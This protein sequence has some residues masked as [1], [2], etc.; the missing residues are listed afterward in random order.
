MKTPFFGNIFNKQKNSYPDADSYQECLEYLKSDQDAVRRDA[1]KSI[2]QNHISKI[3]DTEP[4]GDVMRNDRSLD[5]QNLAMSILGRIGTQECIDQI[6][7]MATLPDSYTRAQAISVLTEMKNVN[8][9]YTLK[10]TYGKVRPEYQHAIK[11]ALDKMREEMHIDDRDAIVSGK[12]SPSMLKAALPKIQETLSENKEAKKPAKQQTMMDFE[13]EEKSPSQSKLSYEIVD[14]DDDSL[15]AGGA[16]DLDGADDDENPLQNLRDSKSQKLLQEAAAMYSASSPSNKMSSRTI[17]D[18]KYPGSEDSGRTEAEQPIF[19]ADQPAVI[20][21]PEKAEIRDDEKSPAPDMNKKTRIS[22]MLA[23]QLQNVSNSPADP[24]ILDAFISAYVSDSE[25]A[26][27]F[28]ASCASEPD[29]P[30]SIQALQAIMSLKNQDRFR[31]IY[32]SKLKSQS[33][34]TVAKGLIP[35]L[36]SDDI[37]TAEAVF[38]LTE[39]S[40]ERVKKFA[41]NYFVNNTSRELSDFLY[42]KITN[43]NDEEKIIGASLLAR[44]DIKDTRKHLKKLLQD[45]GTQDEIILSIFSRLSPAYSDVVIASLPAL[46]QRDDERI[47]L[48]TSKFLEDSDDLI[49]EEYLLRNLQTKDD[50]KL[51]GK[52]ILLLAKIKSRRGEAYLPSMI[53]DLSPYTKLQTAKAICEYGKP[54]YYNLI[55]LA[56]ESDKHPANRIEFVKMAADIYGRNITP[57]LLSMIQNEIPDVKFAIIET[58]GRMEHREY[59]DTVLAVLGQCL[60][61]A[62]LRLVY[63]ALVAQIRL[64]NL[65]FGGNRQVLLGMLWNIVNDKRNPSK[66]RKDSLECLCIAARDESYEVLANIL[67]TEQNESLI[68][69]AMRHISIYNTPK[70][71]ELIREHASSQ[72]KLIA[73][74]ASKIL[75]EMNASY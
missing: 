4:F 45:A 20:N 61:S 67:K 17:P 60:K 25:A 27:R 71:I 55:A 10:G 15:P 50:N 9:Y 19:F 22:E 2:L 44:L 47:Y 52:S 69:T 23:W 56:M 6:A 28:L 43:G 30:R 21:E 40:N 48:E 63:Y 33:P 73:D 72:N 57:K 34:E 38:P 46:M 49:A 42:G 68:M 8:A 37:E 7:Y 29:S 16:F 31:Y 24:E 66:I 62:D 14:D 39:S 11:R 74:T 3:T 26:V 70:T 12:L 18:M 58:I 65:D 59:L 64:G 53:V 75:R 35:L 51:R 41:I 5:V 1:L 32:L 13:S 54:E 36:H